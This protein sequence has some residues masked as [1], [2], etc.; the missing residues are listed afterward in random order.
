MRRRNNRYYPATGRY[1]LV[2]AYKKSFEKVEF[3]T[4]NGDMGVFRDGIFYNM[5]KIFL[6]EEGGQWHVRT[7]KNT[8]IAKKVYKD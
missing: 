1:N 3:I 6:A 5:D 2:I 8:E 7:I 4:V